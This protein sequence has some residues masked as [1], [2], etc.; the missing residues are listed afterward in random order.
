L[1][2]TKKTHIIYLFYFGGFIKMKKTI[3]LLLTLVLTILSTLILTVS[4]SETARGTLGFHCNGNVRP[5]NHDR[6][7][8]ESFTRFGTTNYWILDSHEYVCPNCGRVDWISFSNM[9][10]GSVHNNIQVRHPLPDEPG[11]I[12]EYIPPVTTTE[13]EP[14]ATEPE[15]TATE[16]EPI[17]TEPEPTETEPHTEVDDVTAEPPTYLTSP[18]PETETEPIVLEAVENEE[19]E[20]EAAEAETEAED[21]NVNTGVSLSKAIAITTASIVMVALAGLIKKRKK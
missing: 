20:N 2:V 10:G 12:P 21:I 5:A 6:N 11:Y 8:V 14:T 18:T 9:N 1:T 15:P 3:A 16:P 7:R 19:D 13:P 17:T 4:A